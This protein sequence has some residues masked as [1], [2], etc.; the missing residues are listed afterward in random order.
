MLHSPGEK[1]GETSA[2][3]KT[4]QSNLKSSTSTIPTTSTSISGTLTSQAI[5]P[6]SAE[7]VNDFSLGSYSQYPP[8]APFPHFAN[9]TGPN[10][11]SP[12]E[13]NAREMSF[14]SQASK[15][16]TV[17]R[18][19]SSPFQ[20]ATDSTQYSPTVSRSNGGTEANDSNSLLLLA[21]CASLAVTTDNGACPS[22]GITEVSRLL[23]HA[24]IPFND[25]NYF[26]LFNFSKVS[27]ITD[28]SVYNPNACYQQP[29]CNKRQYQQ[30]N[31]Q[32][33]TELYPFNSQAPRMQLSSSATEMERHQELCHNYPTGNIGTSILSCPLQ[34]ILSHQEPEWH[35][36]NP[37]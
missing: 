14:S 34:D 19:E 13:Y 32:A 2:S 15:L 25:N 21:N 26:V 33:T 37:S 16:T 30:L 36:T 27:S 22:S 29:L 11:Y 6:L 24:L 10:F 7:P 8:D 20:Q 31:Q 4:S 18:D 23:I 12:C 35:I 28:N 1:D 3:T 17:P 5:S 9:D